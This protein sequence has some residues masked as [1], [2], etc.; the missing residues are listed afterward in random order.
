MRAVYLV[1]AVGDGTLDHVAIGYAAAVRDA[2]WVGRS[3]I[4]LARTSAFAF[5]VLL[6]A[7]LGGT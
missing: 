1:P 7:G 6:V 5:A 4:I 3:A 2:V